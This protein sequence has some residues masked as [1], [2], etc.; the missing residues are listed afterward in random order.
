MRAV[1]KSLS[2]SLYRKQVETL[3]SLRTGAVHIAAL[4]TSFARSRLYKLMEAVGGDNIIYTGHKK[5]QMCNN[6]FPGGEG[7]HLLVDESSGR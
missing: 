3:T 6:V 4:T 1:A 5:G 2:D 7:V